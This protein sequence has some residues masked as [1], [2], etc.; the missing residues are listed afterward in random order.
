MGRHH[1]AS[2][3]SYRAMK[4][5]VVQDYLRSGGTERQSVLLARAFAAA[6]HPTHLVTF[7]P[8]GA[9]LPSKP[10]DHLTLHALQR[11]DTRL[12]W[13]APGLRRYARQVAPDVTLCMGRMANSYGGALQ[14]ALPDAAVISTLRTGKKLPLPF[15]RSLQITRHTIANSQAAQQHLCEEHQLSPEQ[16]TVIPNGLVF[17]P[18]KSDEDAAAARRSTRAQFGASSEDIVLVDVA[19]FRPEKNQ[20]A[21]IDAVAHLDPALPWQL[22]LVGDGTTRQACQ[23]HAA[24][25]GLAERVVFPGWCA[26]P[27]PFYAAG[28]IAVHASRRE[29]LSNFLIEAQ[30][31]GLPAIAAAAR[32]VDETFVDGETGLLVRPDDL[33]GFTAACDRLLRDTSLRE[34]MGTM[35]S[36]NARKKFSTAAQVKAHLDLFE[37]LASLASSA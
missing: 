35:G 24:Q 1:P 33:A 10:I 27:R 37:E 17:G 26:D 6:Q 7:R 21:L 2:A 22:W 20:R 32:G 25:L 12:D 18:T 15:R 4:I 9:L 16:T 28:D 11:R 36:R 13:W 3:S 34:A 30:A 19:M 31:H 8:G 29:S 23:Q 14:K 5:L